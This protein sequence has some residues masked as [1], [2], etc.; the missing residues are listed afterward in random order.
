MVAVL[1]PL[2]A[3]AAGLFG[4]LLLFGVILL[5]DLLLTA[6]DVSRV[7]GLV[8]DALR[9]IALAIARAAQAIASL[10]VSVARSAMSV[11]TAPALGFHVA[12]QAISTAISRLSGWVRHLV[13][14]AVPQL[15]HS[16]TAS[17]ASVLNNL[18]NLATQLYRQAIAHANAIRLALE[19][20]IAAGVATA[21][22]YA[23][24]LHRIISH[25][26]TGA[27]ASL[28]AY[29]LSLFR[30]AQVALVGAVG[31]LTSLILNQ[32]AKV[33]NYAYQLAQW[34]VNTAIGIS[35]DWAKKYADHVIDV[36]RAAVGA[37][38]ALA[39]APAWPRILEAIDSI[40]LALPGSIADVLSRVGAI[41]RAIPRDLALE[42]GAVGAI[43]GVAVDWVAQCGLSLCRNTK[44][45]GDDLASLEDAAL[46][47]LI[48]DLIVAG[49]AD[50]DGSA[51][52]LIGDL[53]GELGSLA[54]EASELI[55]IG[56]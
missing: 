19:R 50:P 4:L 35:I 22:A 46:L 29:A 45:F 3:V 40:A 21:V 39:L 28:S 42:L 14:T 43:A 11:F 37:A 8:G 52:D 24:S 41:P 49:A 15:W 7:P 44:G 9:W 55:G 17:I 54:R 56:G 53:G 23:N 51:T 38:G 12:V 31:N 26:L 10:F 1:A 32:I 2:P 27:F 36:Y 20:V 33:T 16:L 13:Y 30:A 48:F 6:I 25:A 5:I 34:A 47:A 18:T